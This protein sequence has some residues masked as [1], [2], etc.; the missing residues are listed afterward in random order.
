MAAPTRSRA[1]KA[2]TVTLP[3]AKETPGTVVY[4][5]RSNAALAINTLYI[6]KDAFEGGQFPASVTVT[7]TPAS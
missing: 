2:I 6:R 4:Q 7:V 1:A 5:D 3:L